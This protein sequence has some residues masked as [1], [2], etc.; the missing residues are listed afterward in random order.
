MNIE[1]LKVTWPRVPDLAVSD[2]GENDWYLRNDIGISLS[3][4]DHIEVFELAIEGPQ[5]K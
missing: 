1:T 3:K 5:L 4:L 2:R